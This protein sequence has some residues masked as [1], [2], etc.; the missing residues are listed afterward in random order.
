M[1][2][3]C[4]ARE[5]VEVGEGGEEG[6]AAVEAFGQSAS[7]AAVAAEVFVR[8]GSEGVPLAG[9]AEDLAKEIEALQDGGELAGTG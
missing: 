1:G 6:I 2:V 3:V 5:V 9:G 7:E 4:E 8:R